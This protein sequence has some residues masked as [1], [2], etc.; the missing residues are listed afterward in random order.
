MKKTRKRKKRVWPKVRLLL[1]GGAVGLLVGKGCTLVHHS[2][3]GQI[4]RDVTYDDLDEDVELKDQFDY[5]YNNDDSFNQ[6]DGKASSENYDVREDFSVYSYDELI[7]RCQT[8]TLRQFAMKKIYNYI[9]DYNL[10]SSY[11]YKEDDLDV[12]LSHTVD[13]V[14]AMY[15]FYNDLE[16]EEIGSIFS[17]T[18]LDFQQLKSILI[19]AQYQSSLAHNIQTRSLNKSCLLIKPEDQELYN[20]YEK[21]FIDMNETYDFDKKTNFVKKFNQMVREDLTGMATNDYTN[22]GSKHLIIKEFVDAMR[23]VEIV[24]DYPLT[25]QEIKYID[26]LLENV[27]SQKINGIEA[28]QNIGNGDLADSSLNN[29]EIVDTNPYYSDFREAI[30]KELEDKKSYSTIE[31]D[32]DVTLLKSFNMNT[33]SRH[34][35]NIAASQVNFQ[36]MSNEERA[37]YIISQIEQE[38][39]DYG[40]DNRLKTRG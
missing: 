8:N 39:L 2:V 19:S 15:L 30:I 34:D 14:A 37:D 20:R 11:F 27:V 31:S 24:V 36:D 4:E 16:M 21:I 5:E 28:L 40:E 35:Q 33:K 7:Q 9:N 23:R 25:D 1:I 29:G 10:V 3:E 22:V 18:E 32:R 6:Y 38:M 17:Q 26:G 12:K 13:E